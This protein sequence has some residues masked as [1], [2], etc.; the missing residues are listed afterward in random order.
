MDNENKLSELDA[1]VELTIPEAIKDVPSTKRRV[2][3]IDGMN[4]FIR[5]F[6][7]VGI[8]NENGEFFGGVFGTLQTIKALA[9]TFNP[10]IIIW[11]WEG[12]NSGRRRR[13]LFEGYKSGRKT[14]KSLSRAYEFE[15]PEAEKANMK[16]QLLRIKDYLSYLPIYQLEVENLEADDVIA[17]I[18]N[19]MFK[20]DEKIIVSS[21]KDYW[22]L[23]NEKV[24]VYRPVKKEI[25]DKNNILSIV[26]VSPKNY[27]LYKT[28][29]GDTSDDIPQLKKGLGPKT[30]VKMFPFLTEEK[31]YTVDDLIEYS[32]TQ[33]D[34]KYQDFL[35]EEAR[36]TLV[37]NY[38]L[39]QLRDHD[40][41]IAAVAKIRETFLTNQPILSTSKLMISFLQDRLHT[42]ARRYDDWHKIFV[43]CNWQWNQLK[44]EKD[45]Q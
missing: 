32:K 6:V 5:N 38:D 4:N 33:T 3:L 25:I 13:E 30:L 23:I 26:G 20:D 43:R 40:M 9:S 28:V 24:R 1:F 31:S 2:L 27:T 14:V 11:C 41:N 34:K 39:V 42:Q 29:L 7:V 17:Y 15:S 21:D 44:E 45:I 35:T 37:R 36:T 18:T 8:T 12:R 22:Q 16:F 10:H 19:N